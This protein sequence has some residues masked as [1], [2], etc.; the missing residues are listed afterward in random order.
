MTAADGDGDGGDGAGDVYTWEWEV[1][2]FVHR[3]ANMARVVDGIKH[4]AEDAMARG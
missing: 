1:P 2:C 4:D 3:T